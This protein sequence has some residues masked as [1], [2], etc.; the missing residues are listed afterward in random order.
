MLIRTCTNSPSRPVSNGQ[1]GQASGQTLIDSSMA[2]GLET[3]KPW[4]G[5]S[6]GLK[7]LGDR[8]AFSTFLRG[9]N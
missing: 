9:C 6:Q 2:I 3:K 4:T 5:E 8:L 1:R 7:I